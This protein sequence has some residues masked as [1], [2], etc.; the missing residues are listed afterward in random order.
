[1]AKVGKW[2]SLEKIARDDGVLD[3]YPTLAKQRR[4]ATKVLG[5][6]IQLDDTGVEGC[7]F[8]D[9]KEEKTVKV[10]KRISNSR[11][12]QKEY[13]TQGEVDSAA[14][15]SSHEVACTMASKDRARRDFQFICEIQSSCR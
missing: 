3:K 7:V 4:Y 2:R 8:C 6:E 9:D 13:E 12:H 5:L 1:L 14:A 11:I 10:G 15:K